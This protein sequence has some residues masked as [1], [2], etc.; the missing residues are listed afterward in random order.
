MYAVLG[1]DEQINQ[2]VHVINMWPS[3]E[4]LFLYSNDNR[5]WRSDDDRIVEFYTSLV[6]ESRDDDN[7]SIVWDHTENVYRI[8]A[9]DGGT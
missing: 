5:G 7:T 8:Y 9:F 2:H 1:S 6:L 4:G 3:S